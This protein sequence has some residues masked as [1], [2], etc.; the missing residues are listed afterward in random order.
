M[1]IQIISDAHIEFH[2]DRGE[3]FVN[4]LQSDADTLVIAGDLATFHSFWVLKHLCKNYKHVLYVLGNHEYWGSSYEE[5]W[6]QLSIVSQDCP[7]L[8]ILDNRVVTIE[9][10]KFVGTTLWFEEL[11][12]SIPYQTMWS[13]FHKI[14]D[15]WKWVFV[16][17]QKA[18]EFLYR[19]VNQNSIVITHHLPMLACTADRWKK[20]VNTDFFVCDM[21]NLIISRRPK[22]WIYGHTHNS[23][24]FK[25]EET[26]FVC[27][28]FGYLKYEENPEFDWNKIVEI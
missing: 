7:N 24:D 5:V 6:K 9:G 4:E 16:H 22:L 17:N 2:Q 1:R 8:E 15:F 25:F 20:D 14:Q 3:T 28:P 26:R 10:Q 12:R 23:F 11:P 27:N 13:D 21:E 18:Q 19:K